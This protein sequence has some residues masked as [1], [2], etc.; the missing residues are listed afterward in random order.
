MH[1]FCR[2]IFV[3][4]M[5][6]NS[7]AQ[8]ADW[9]IE[10][11]MSALSSQ[12]EGHAT[13]VE[14]T[15]LKMLDRPLES[16]GELSFVAPDQLQKVTLKPKREALTLKGD[17]LSIERKGRVQRL[18]VSDYPQVAVF[19]DSIRATLMGDGAAL[20]RAYRIALSGSA[21]QWELVLVPK[22]EAEK[23]IRKITING[24]DSA[25]HDV[26]IVQADGDRSVMHIDHSS[27]APAALSEPAH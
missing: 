13:F 20:E 24:A 27:V 26:E 11:L 21:Q 10:Q 7:G 22:G 23:T 14:T 9:A 3:L 25:L 6:L 15:Y 17:E 18:R 5:L 19:V 4:L 16:S 2:H 8:A 12:R 1:K